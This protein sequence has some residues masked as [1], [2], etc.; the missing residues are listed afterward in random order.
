MTGNIEHRNLKD[1]IEKTLEGKEVA[2]NQMMLVKAKI[3][4]AFK[5][6]DEKEV[7]KEFEC[8]KKHFLEELENGVEMKKLVANVNM[9]TLMSTKIVKLLPNGKRHFFCMNEY[10]IKGFKDHNDAF[11]E[12]LTRFND[13]L[14]LQFFGH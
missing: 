12:Y 14:G 5:E 9:A 1:D 6:Q 13:K 2:P 11:A 10:I 8:V 4:E 3:N 7:G